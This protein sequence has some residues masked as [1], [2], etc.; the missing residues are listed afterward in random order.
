MFGLKKKSSFKV[1]APISG[2]C[3]PLT[4]VN[5]DVFSKKMV[6]DGFVLKPNETANTVVSPIDATVEMLPDSKH[7]IGIKSVNTPIE[8]LVH[9][10]LDT[11]KLNGTGFEALVKQGD[12]VKAGQ[13]VIKFDPQIMAKQKL[14]MSTMVI[15]TSGYQQPIDLGSKYQ[16]QVTAGQ[17]LLIAK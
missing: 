14:D 16:Q 13:P 7:A 9:I 17:T 2:V 3:Q 4:T 5:D 12:Q 8:L 10:G 11:V 15:F 6:G 1:V